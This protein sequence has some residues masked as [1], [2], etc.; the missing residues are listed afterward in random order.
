MVKMKA[1]FRLLFFLIV[2]IPAVGFSQQPDTLRRKL[3]SL[4]FKTDSAGGQTNNTT[5]KAY[6]NSTR[7]NF[8][9]YI[10][11]L[12]SDFKQSFTKPFHMSGKDWGN[13]GKFALVAGALDRK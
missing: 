11:L 1:K 8:K 3:D 13:L 4:S 10:I 6:N 12:S 2:S 5:P 9:T 7:L